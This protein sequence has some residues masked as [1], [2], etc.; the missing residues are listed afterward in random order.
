MAFTL[1]DVRNGQH[2]IFSLQVILSFLGDYI[3]DEIVIDGEAY[4]ISSL[5]ETGGSGGQISNLVWIQQSLTVS[6]NGQT[7]FPVL[8]LT[9]DL[10]SL[11]LSVNRI[12]YFHG[13][14]LDFHVE[15]G[16]LDW[17]A[18]FALETTDQMIL[19]YPMILQ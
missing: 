1:Q 3:N 17:H 19:R 15:S 6:E 18:G 2:K 12:N 5:V 4:R 8:L 14:A 9:E 11:Q 7:A 13:A 10:D 16:V